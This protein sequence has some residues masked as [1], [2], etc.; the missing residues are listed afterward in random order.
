MH[1]NTQ[2]KAKSPFHQGEQRVQQRFGVRDK[3]ERF[4]RQVIRDYM[5]EQHQDFYTQ[6][7]FV[8]VGHADKNGWP[9]ASILF[10]QSNL[11]TVLDE[12][13]LRLNVKPVK[14][15]PLQNSLDKGERWGLLGIELSTRRRN[16]LAAHIQ[17]V[18]E[19]GITLEVD[20][21]FG[22]CPQYIQQRKHH[23][24]GPSN[25]PKEA[26]TQITEFDPKIQNLIQTSD[27]FF[28]AS[29]VANGSGS[30]SEGA[31]VSHR[32]GKPGFIRIDDNKTLTIPDYTG[33][34]HFNTLGNFVENPKAGLLFIDFVNGHILTLTGTVEILWD[35]QETEF[36]DGAERLWTFTLDH[37]YS[38]KNVLPL[39][40]DLPDYSANTQ[41]TGSWKEAEQ[42]KKS[43]ELKNTWQDYTVTNIVRESSVITSF[44]LQSPEGQNPNFEAGQFLTVKSFIDAKEQVRTYTVSNAP[45]D[46]LIRISIKHEQAQSGKPSGVFSSFMH[47]KISIG[48]V[49]QAKSPVG[50]FKLVSPINKPI[51]LISAGVGI[52]P[53]IAMAQHILQECFRTR[54]QP[55]VTLVCS[56][57]NSEQRAFFVELNNLVEQA[58]GYIRVIWILSQPE[59]NLILGADYHYRGRLSKPLLET[60]L[61]SIKCD[62]YLCG[63]NEFMQ[64]QYDN[65]R[66]LGVENKQIFSE[67]FGPSSLQRDKS[68]ESKVPV[69]EEAMIHFT[70]SKVE[71]AWTKGDG[72]LLEF[73]EA[74]GLQPEFSCRSGQCGA[75]KVKLNKGQVSYQQNITA[76]IT[77]DEILLCSAMPAKSA[78]N[79]PSKLEIEL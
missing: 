67:A 21:A 48:D 11:I 58:S 45:K 34:F 5:P 27:T 13:K 78:G 77:E 30:V 44:Y 9:W 39:R 65:L 35:S 46:K 19:Q 66:A 1:T 71:Q 63:P 57:R 70:K 68:I 20:Q 40:W 42:A 75:C 7:P 32:G 25:M 69:A 38:L 49:L 36:F 55:N 14:G 29:Y 76:E 10:N 41:L 28:V 22:N 43:S 37:G 54:S 62:A 18:S 47:Q 24:I 50:A 61:P 60:L 6:L 52:T 53:M 31:D 26:C 74:H 12:K 4:G 8:F 64:D 2:E 33:N 59:D 16:R 73:A 79:T 72:T 17:H 23:S 15:D 3:M 51:M 56:A